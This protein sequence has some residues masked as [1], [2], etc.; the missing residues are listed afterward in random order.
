MGYIPESLG[1]CGVVE[2]LSLYLSFVASKYTTKTPETSPNGP[3]SGFFNKK[4]STLSVDY[5]W[6]TNT[7]GN[8]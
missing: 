3:F 8:P 7:Q 6:V 5:M 1:K 4:Y 2:Y